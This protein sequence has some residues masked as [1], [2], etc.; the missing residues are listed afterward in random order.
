M[1][2]K[3][4]TKLKFDIENNVQQKFTFVTVLAQRLHIFPNQHIPHMCRVRYRYPVEKLQI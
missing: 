2:N 3:K 1:P 4:S